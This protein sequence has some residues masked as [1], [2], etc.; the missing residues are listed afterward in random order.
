MTFVEPLPK[1]IYEKAKKLGVKLIFLEFSGGSDEGYLSVNL[2]SNDCFADD[3]KPGLK[4]NSDDE[5]NAFNDEV[6]EW[7]EDAYCYSGA[8]DGSDYGDDVTYN[9]EEKTVAHSQ[10]YSSPQYEP[11]ETIELEITE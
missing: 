11:E 4:P 5:W 10:W 6:H 3:F 1:A 2:T 9:I 7:A 8:G